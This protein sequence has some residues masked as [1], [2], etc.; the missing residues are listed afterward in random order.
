M[1]ICA[2]LIISRESTIEFTRKY[3]A[4]KYGGANDSVVLGDAVMYWG[5]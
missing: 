5:V 4:F 1:R 3:T 2:N